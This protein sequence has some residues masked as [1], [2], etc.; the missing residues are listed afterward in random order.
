MAENI[1]EQWN[2]QAQFNQTIDQIFIKTHDYLAK[3][4]WNIWELLKKFHLKND[5]YDWIIDKT[6]T[7]IEKVYHEKI[8]KLQNELKSEKKTMNKQALI[9]QLIA[10]TMSAKWLEINEI[11][12][13]WKEKLSWSE[14]EKFEGEKTKIFEKND[15]LK[16]ELEN[17]SQNI[18]ES[19]INWEKLKEKK[20]KKEEVLT[21]NAD[22][23]IKKRLE[24]KINQEEF[25]NEFAKILN[26]WEK[27]WVSVK[28]TQ[29]VNELFKKI[30][31]SQI[32]K[33]WE[34]SLTSWLLPIWM[35]ATPWLKKLVP[36]LPAFIWAWIWARLMHGS[37]MDKI[38]AV[39]ET[40][41]YIAPISGTF[42][43]SADLVESFN[44]WRKWEWDLWDVIANLLWFFVSA[45][46]DWMT[47]M[48]VASWIGI[49]AA[50]WLSAVKWAFIQS[51]KLWVKN[52][53]KIV[54]REAFKDLE[55]NYDSVFKVAKDFVVENSKIAWKVAISNP[56]K[57]IQQIFKETWEWL[58]SIMTFKWLR[59]TKALSKINDA[60]FWK[61]ADALLP[62]KIKAF[63]ELEKVWIVPKWATE[64]ITTA[65]IEQKALLNEVRPED[66]DTMMKENEL[67]QIETT[68]NRKS[69][70]L[71]FQKIE[72]TWHEWSVNI[73][74]ESLNTLIVK[75]EFIW[76]SINVLQEIKSMISKNMD[77][78]EILKYLKTN[79]DNISNSLY[80]YIEDTINLDWYKSHRL[81]LIENKLSWNIPKNTKEQESLFEAILK[82]ENIEYNP[83]TD[84]NKEF[85]EQKWLLKAENK[86]Y[87]EDNKRILENL[88]WYLKD[89]DIIKNTAKKEILL[90][91]YLE[92]LKQSNDKSIYVK[93][94]TELLENKNFKDVNYLLYDSIEAKYIENIKI[95]NKEENKILRELSKNQIESSLVFANKLLNINK[96]IP[97]TN[98]IKD[99]KEWKFTQ[100]SVNHLIEKHQNM[101]KWWTWEKALWDLIEKLEKLWFKNNTKLNDNIN[102]E[103]ILKNWLDEEW[104]V[105]DFKEYKRNLVKNLIENKDK[106]DKIELRNELKK[107]M[108]NSENWIWVKENIELL[109]LLEKV[110]I[111]NPRAEE[112]FDYIEAIKESWV[113]ELRE[114]TSYIKEYVEK[115]NKDIEKEHESWKK[116]FWNSKFINW[117]KVLWDK[118]LKFSENLKTEDHYMIKLIIDDIWKWRKWLEAKDEN[119][120]KRFESRLESWEYIKIW[121]EYFATK[122]NPNRYFLWQFLKAEN[123]KRAESY[124]ELIHDKSDF[125]WKT[126]K[127][128]FNDPSLSTEKKILL[129]YH[130]DIKYDKEVINLI[131][132]E[133][134]NPKYAKE[135]VYVLQKRKD[136]NMLNSWDEIKVFERWILE[137]LITK[138]FLETKEWKK[139]TDEEFNNKKNIII[140]AILLSKNSKIQELIQ[141]VR[142]W[143]ESLENTKKITDE[144]ILSIKESKDI[145]SEDKIFAKYIYENKD[146]FARLLW[147]KTK[148][149]DDIKNLNNSDTIKSI[150]T[151][152]RWNNSIS[153]EERIFRDDFLKIYDNKEVIK[154]LE[155]WDWKTA[156]TKDIEILQWIETSKSLVRWAMSEE[157]LKETKNSV[158]ETPIKLD[159]DLQEKFSF[160]WFK[161]ISTP[162]K[163]VFTLVTLWIMS[164]TEAEASELEIRDKWKTSPE[165]KKFI[166]MWG[167]KSE[168]AKKLREETV[169]AITKET[170]KPFINSVDDKY[171]EMMEKKVAEMPLLF[172]AILWDMNTRVKEKINKNHTPTDINKLNNYMYQYVKS[173]KDYGWS[174]ISNLDKILNNFNEL[175]WTEIE[176]KLRTLW[177]LYD[178]IAKKEES[179]NNSEKKIAETEKEIDKLKKEKEAL[180]KEEERYKKLSAER[181][182]TMKWL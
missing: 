150:I 28:L 65:H 122:M 148:L 75:D 144:I 34:R 162:K 110:W 132:K 42:M 92:I 93:K 8:L 38:K 84:L 121:N 99:N 68:K 90:E 155:N 169:I 1:K 170:L 146:I 67:K 17:L 156:W 74:E 161:N 141:S 48:A 39:W 152:I 5:N 102:I 130:E 116:D 31:K 44:K 139:L 22:K 52:I 133:R 12:K 33:I 147:E 113:D 36:V 91:K 94:I 89:K 13:L 127:E 135:I 111:I 4:E 108:Q 182:K 66:S 112:K 80:K 46:F 32:E 30:E 120:L 58:Y 154:N 158:V 138:E 153:E 9:S 45:W 117:D 35:I 23:L 62:A 85:L 50:V 181:E 131:L 140:D 82:A 81:A 19:F 60:T 3:L 88:E 105:I 151:L 7:H 165:Y 77:S 78:K 55:R 56:K 26:E 57:V 59:E 73:F 137:N 174:C 180:K 179:I 53:N 176:K 157:N 98:I 10:M 64:R 106:L 101:K 160:M 134:E 142:L 16:N 97:I 103:T 96:N 124:M 29:N 177:E 163:L 129:S 87:L 27:E 70:D 14:L 43:A 172:Q 41:L 21:N 128:I 71:L 173:A 149:L 118:I 114:D 63:K 115:I 119:S 11:S 125:W 49:P 40:I 20:D 178:S 126:I 37:T 61:A 167:E 24:N 72:N 109:K 123:T 168:A 136:L 51:C 104:K 6:D 143:E 145:S 2:W 25:E 166:E 76:K 86:W 175:A 79:E 100:T 107:L 164:Q 15:E 171:K 47:L 159:S 83:K 54:W 69:L 18:D 95:N